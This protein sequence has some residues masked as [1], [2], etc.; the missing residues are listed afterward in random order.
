M[1]A[2]SVRLD[3]FEIQ[4][5]MGNV[6]TNALYAN[7]RHQCKVV[8]LIAK[9]VDVHGLWT[10]SELTPT[11][12]DSLTITEYSSNPD[13]P[14]PVGWSVD[15]DKN[16]YDSG[17]WR[18]R[19]TDQENSRSVKA[20]SQRAFI[21]GRVEMLER[22]LRVNPNQ[23]IEVKRFM[24]RIKVGGKVYTTNYQDDDSIFNSRVEV[25]PVRP[26]ILRAAD[27]VHYPDV[28]VY[29]DKNKNIHVDVHY[30]K[31]PRG[32]VFIQNVGISNPLDVK[33]EGWSFKTSDLTSSGFNLRKCGIV[34]GKDTLEQRIFMSDVQR[35]IYPDDGPEIEFNRWR[36]VMRAIMLDG[37]V[38][39]L[40]GRGN[41]HWTV[42]DNYGCEHKYRLLVDFSPHS[43]E[44]TD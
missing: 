5:E 12:R 25:Q 31:P 35:G 2:G 40:S 7:G 37:G 23:P 36:T 8:V 32:L 27:L 6:S 18:E 29:E 24:A 10:F 20:S 4:T 43:V 42:L 30:W 9:K 39:P 13:A 26:Y 17:L 28:R 1:T 19:S 11:E 44:L 15:R 16:I 22:F 14:L 3:H 33:N 34:I 38:S 41:G 21:S